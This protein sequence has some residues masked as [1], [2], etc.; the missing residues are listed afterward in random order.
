MALEIQDCDG[1]FDA[2]DGSRDGDGAL[3]VATAPPKTKMH[4]EIEF[5]NRMQRQI[6]IRHTSG[7]RIVA[8]LELVSP[9]KKWNER[10]IKSFAE[11]AQRALHSGYHLLI[12][13]LFPPTNRD[14]RG[15]HGVIGEALGVFDVPFDSSE[16]LTL[17]A[18]CSG[19]SIGCFVEPTAVGRPLTDMP[20]FLTPE[21]YINVPLEPTYTSAYR[22]VPRRWKVIL[23]A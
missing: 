2:D 1:G 10:S 8:L 16:P 20:L 23:D 4:S 21:R 14:P 6:A 11:K 12:V 19:A 18:Y 3:A 17:A 13:D 15:I 5:E 22:G 7:D 9:G